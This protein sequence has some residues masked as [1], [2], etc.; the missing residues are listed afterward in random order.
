M[1]QSASLEREQLLQEIEQLQ[2]LAAQYGE[3]VEWKDQWAHG[4]L[5]TAVELRHLMLTDLN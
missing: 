2:A 5:S 4:L 1:H 3:S